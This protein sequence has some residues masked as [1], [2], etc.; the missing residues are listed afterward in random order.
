MLHA[1]G[2]TMNFNVKFTVEQIIGNRKVPFIHVQT[3]PSDFMLTDQLIL[4]DLADA[5]ADG[6]Q[7]I[8]NEDVKRHSEMLSALFRLIGKHEVISWYR[9]PAT[10]RKLNGAENSLHLL[11]LA[12]DI[13][14]DG[15]TEDKAHY[16][17]D[18]WE[19]ICKHFKVIGAIKV[20]PAYIH[21]SSYESVFGATHFVSEYNV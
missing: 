14:V 9:S 11:G 3:L 2:T 20:Y 8:W 7:A 13:K 4:S 16:Y 10:N 1:K 12:T 19:T 6:F 5:D 15:M 18:A 21:L 17:V